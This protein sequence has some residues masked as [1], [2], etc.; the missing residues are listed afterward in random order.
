MLNFITGVCA[1]R[2]MATTKWVIESY[3]KI[4]VQSSEFAWQE[5]RLQCEHR[6][7]LVCECGCAGVYRLSFILLPISLARCVRVDKKV[8]YSKIIAEK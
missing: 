3:H 4:I 1:F 6:F 8:L 5:P 7:G 2:T